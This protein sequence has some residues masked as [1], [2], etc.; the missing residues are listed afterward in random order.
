MSAYLAMAIYH[1]MTLYQGML[2]YQDSQHILGHPNIPV[3]TRSMAL[4][5]FKP[6]KF[7]YVHF[8]S[9]GGLKESTC[10]ERSILG[11]QIERQVLYGLLLKY[12]TLSILF[13]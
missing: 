10:Q 1:G 6:P 7:C 3:I 8:L 13:C 9:R 4:E 11:G 2:T 5:V 12:F